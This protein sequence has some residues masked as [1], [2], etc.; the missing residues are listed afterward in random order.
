MPL[1]TF[2]E[3]SNKAAN[4]SELVT[5]WQKSMT[6]LGFDRVLFSLLTDHDVIGRKAGH[7]VAVN[8]PKEWLAR[9]FEGG[10]EL[11]RQH[12][13]AT[14]G[15]FGWDRVVKDTKLKTLQIGLFNEGPSTGFYNGI[16]IPLRGP[17]GGIAGITAAGRAGD[18][19]LS[20]DLLDYARLISQQFYKT[21]LRFEAKSDGK[22]NVSLTDRE[23]EV[24]VWYSQGKA[25]PDIAIIM[26][27]TP[28]M[29]QLYLKNI[30]IKLGVQNGRVAVLKAAT[31]G[32]IFP[33]GEC[34]EKIAEG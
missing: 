16:G 32:L 11:M 10:F 29:V 20:E 15:A 24:L 21:F 30:F 33:K 4:A 3:A 6:A 9:Y 19:V 18:V 12:M 7:I 34:L 1:Q 13:F 27:I 26:A 5:V 17:L 8:F 25:Q 28:S 31:M 2:I 22:R 23:K 14:E